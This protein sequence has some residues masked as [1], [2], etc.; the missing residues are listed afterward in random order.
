MG[1]SFD[2]D[3]DGGGI[4]SDESTTAGSILVNINQRIAEVSSPLVDH[5]HHHQLG[6]AS[7]SSSVV[8]WPPIRRGHR[9]ANQTKSVGE[10]ASS[11]ALKSDKCSDAKEVV[12][13]SGYQRV[14]VHMDGMLIGRKVD[15]NAHD[16][17]ETLAQTL[18]AMFGE[19]GSSTEA[20]GPLK[21]LDATSEFVLTFADKDGDYMF[22]RDV[23]WQMFLSSVKRLR[24]M[25]NSECSKLVD[26]K[27]TMVSPTCQEK[28]TRR[29]T[30]GI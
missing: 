25:K 15:L 22:V 20:A 11:A 28:K 23:P 1:D 19:N 8:G 5:H 3:G 17:Y 9:L 12:G 13:T 27:R 14:K 10:Q 18:E 21:L 24:I 2:G 16:S 29:S 26:R 30:D 7:P 6:L 4:S